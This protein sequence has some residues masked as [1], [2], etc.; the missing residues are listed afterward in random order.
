MLLGRPGGC[1]RRHLRG[2]RPVRACRVQTNPPLL[3]L[4]LPILH[5][6]AGHLCL[7]GLAPSKRLDGLPAGR[8]RRLPGLCSSRAVPDRSRGNAARA[9]ASSGGSPVTSA[10]GRATSQHASRRRQCSCSRGPAASMHGRRHAAHTRVHGRVSRATWRV[11]RNHANARVAWPVGCVRPG[12]GAVGQG[13]SVCRVKGSRRSVVSF[14]PRVAATAPRPVQP[15]RDGR[16]PRAP[17][18]AHRLVA[19]PATALPPS[20]ERS[21]SVHGERS[22]ATRR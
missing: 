11:C 19:P 5:Y 10:P 15:G 8:S 17:A 2:N 16:V 14:S 4:L 9:P 18:G 7:L 12:L 1:D 3:Q 22:R 6:A 21:S 13:I 20:P